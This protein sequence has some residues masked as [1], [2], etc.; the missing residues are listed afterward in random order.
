MTCLALR[1]PGV[2]LQAGRSCLRGCST[3]PCMAGVPPSHAAW[4]PSMNGATPSLAACW[5]SPARGTGPGASVNVPGEVRHYPWHVFHCQ[6]EGPH[7]K[8]EGL[9]FKSEVRYFESEG[10]GL[11]SEVQ[12]HPWMMLDKR[13]ATA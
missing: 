4:K 11:E 9:H 7:F 13:R 10:Q 1:D 8:T 12:H 3:T 6:S 2:P 5:L